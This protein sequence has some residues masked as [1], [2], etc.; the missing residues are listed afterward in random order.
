MALDPNAAIN[1]LLEARNLSPDSIAI[2]QHLSMVLSFANRTEEALSELDQCIKLAPN[3]ADNYIDKA[4][5]LGQS[6]QLEKALECLNRAIGINPKLGA[7]YLDR[8]NVYHLMSKDE[9]AEKDL[10]TAKKLGATIEQEIY[11][12]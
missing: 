10:A 8:A 9:L 7:A 2:R 3:A 12:K 1:E 5:L 4:V 11:S 6:G